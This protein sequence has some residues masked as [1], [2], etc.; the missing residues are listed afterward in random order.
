MVQFTYLPRFEAC[1]EYY[2]N[3]QGQI[4][5]TKGINVEFIDTKEW[6]SPHSAWIFAS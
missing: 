3:R 4:K 6:V 5:S 2:V 1:I